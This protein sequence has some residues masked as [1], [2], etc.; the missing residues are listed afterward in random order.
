MKQ[1]PYELQCKLAVQLTTQ[2]ERP[3]DCGYHTWEELADALMDCVDLE[4]DGEPVTVCYPFE[5][6]Y[7][8]AAVSVA[9]DLV[10]G[11]ATAVLKAEMPE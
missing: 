4:C 8:D 2:I 1:L 5:A 11:I 3:E 10:G 7:L 9:L 6:F